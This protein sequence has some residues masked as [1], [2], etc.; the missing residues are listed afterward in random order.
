MTTELTH[1]ALTATGYSG[2]D[3]AGT[4][5]AEQLAAG[6]QTIKG[7]FSGN[8]TIPGGDDAR[9]NSRRIVAL[10]L[11]YSPTAVRLEWFR[12][13]QRDDMVQ[14]EWRTG[15]EADNLGFHVYREENGQLVRLTPEPVAGSALL[16]GKGTTLGA[17]LSYFWWDF[18]PEGSGGVRY[19]LEDIDLGGKRTRHGPVTPVLSQEPLPE[20]F[21]PE[22]LSE[23]GM[24]LEE[25]YRHYWR[26]QELKEKLALKRL[27][28]KGA[29]SF[30]RGAALRASRIEASAS[31][32]V[33]LK[34]SGPFP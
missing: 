31:N 32:A 19:W 11:A 26:V 28:A 3:S 10:W 1:E 23:L 20:R 21:R 30:P 2:A 25:R 27:E 13:R 18:L 17:G 6:S 33:L 34:R 8:N 14:L 29:T 16:A 15:Y 24:R 22:L 9:I 12:A 4:A 5:Y 7:R